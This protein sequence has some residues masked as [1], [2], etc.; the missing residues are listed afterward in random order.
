MTAPAFRRGTAV[1]VGLALFLLPAGPVLAISDGEVPEPGLGLVETLLLF[2]GIPLGIFGLIALLIVASGLRH[3]P[4]YRP[5]RSW[6]CDP[7]WFA[8][9]ADPAAALV[10]ARP[11][12]EVTGGGASAEW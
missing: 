4:R 6:D 7:I 3:R 9:P 1:V 5:G 8:G 2:G 10:A 12:P 11:G